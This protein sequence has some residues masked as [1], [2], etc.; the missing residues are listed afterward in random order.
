MHVLERAALAWP[1]F[2]SG[3]YWF[4]DSPNAAAY[5]RNE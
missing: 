2:I 3:P 5:D 1:M 4:A